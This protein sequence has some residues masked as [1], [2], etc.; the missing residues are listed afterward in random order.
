MEKII[1]CISLFEGS[2]LKREEVNNF[3]GIFSSLT[4]FQ[5]V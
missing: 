4:I 2:G 1:A 5:N 3:K